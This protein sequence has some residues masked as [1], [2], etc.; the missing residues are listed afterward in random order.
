V[1][2]QTT[3]LLIEDV[4]SGKWDISFI[5]QDQIGTILNFTAHRSLEHGYRPERIPIRT[6]TT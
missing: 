1:I 4:N 3:K 2:Y 5:A 6:T